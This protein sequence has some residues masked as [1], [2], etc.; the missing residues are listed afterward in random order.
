MLSR[1][2]YMHGMRNISRNFQIIQQQVLTSGAF[3]VAVLVDETGKGQSMKI[4]QTPDPEINTAMAFVAMEPRY[5]PA[6]C[7]GRPC[8]MY[9]PIF[10]TFEV[11][12]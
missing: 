1:W 11:K 7:S 5:K 3:Y 8:A 6:V 9:F 2:L 12:P 10:V 4:Y